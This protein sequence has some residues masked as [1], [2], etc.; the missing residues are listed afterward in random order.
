MKLSIITVC[1][2]SEA[3]IEDTI[4]SVIAQKNKDVEYII[5]DGKS[6]DKTMEI[7]DRYRSVIDVVI[8]EKDRGI[9]DAFNKGI[10]VAKGQYIALLNSDDRYMDG[11]V[12]R[13]FKRVRDDTD[14]F[15]GNGIRLY[16]DGKVK[17]YMAN[18][19]Y[20]LLYKRM[21]IVH[22]SSFVRKCA[23]EK[24]GMYREDLKYIMDRACFLNMLMKGATFQYDK[25]FYA[26]YS[27]G[28]VS[29]KSYLSGVVPESYRMD[30]AN[31]SHRIIAM[32]NALRRMIK[33]YLVKV[34][35]IVIKN[36]SGKMDYG[37]LLEIISKE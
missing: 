9:S 37:E 4:K 15:Y 21:P 20:S 24:Y 28:G 19:D 30:V 29:D 2:N 14:V 26:I 34:K 31:G 25:G 18:P 3:T 1:Y 17:R 5:V 32:K 35:T 12:E 36:D 7:V 13:F 22:P 16:E 6:S 8:S 23:Y 10:R 33:Y 11:A 27:M